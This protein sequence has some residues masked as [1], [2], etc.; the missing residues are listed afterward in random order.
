MQCPCQTSMA[1][2]LENRAVVLS[3]A[4]EAKRDERYVAHG[5]MPRL[6]HCWLPGKGFVLHCYGSSCLTRDTYVLVS[7]PH[8]R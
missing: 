4:M 6:L 3:K 7:P 1:V 8:L 2:N 5:Q